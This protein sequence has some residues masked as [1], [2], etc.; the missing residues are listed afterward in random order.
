MCVYTR[1]CRDWFADFLEKKKGLYLCNMQEFQSV[2][3]L[4]TESDHPEVTLCN[5]QDVKIQS[6]N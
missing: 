3:L 4:A 2:H 6:R 5:S 1:L